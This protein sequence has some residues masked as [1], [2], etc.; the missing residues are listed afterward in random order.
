MLEAFDSMTNGGTGIDT[1]G[2]MPVRASA[3]LTPV[4][5]GGWPHEGLRAGIDWCRSTA[6]T[7]T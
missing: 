6:S 1:T 4:D 5:A 2:E 7:W 3:M